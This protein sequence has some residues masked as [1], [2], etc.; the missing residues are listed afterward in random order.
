MYLINSKKDLCP[1]KSL[2]TEFSKSVIIRLQQGHVGLN[3]YCEGPPPPQISQP[4]NSD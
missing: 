2:N 1:V 4:S 3:G